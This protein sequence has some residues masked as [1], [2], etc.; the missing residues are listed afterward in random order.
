[1]CNSYKK[2]VAFQVQRPFFIFPRQSTKQRPQFGTTVPDMSLPGNVLFLVLVLVVRSFIFNILGEELYYRGALLPKMCGVFG[3]WAWAANGVLFA[4]KHGGLSWVIPGILPVSLGLACYAGPL[5]SLP[6]A[7]LV[8]W[9]GKDLEL[10]PAV[11]KAVLG[12]D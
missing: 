3:D 2:V 7:I 1:L 8:H 6:L 5:G 10:I 11:V 4:F 12:A 9:L